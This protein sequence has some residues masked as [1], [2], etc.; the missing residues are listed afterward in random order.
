MIW[1][2]DNNKVVVLH[3]RG[4]F[5]LSQGLN[6]VSVL[7]QRNTQQ[8]NNG[9]QNRTT[10]VPGTTHTKLKQSATVSTSL[11]VLQSSRKY[12]T[13]TNKVYCKS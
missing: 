11:F 5:V 6:Y 4:C 12:R 9:A 10:I 8:K 2:T 7:L 1:L 13:S 3:T